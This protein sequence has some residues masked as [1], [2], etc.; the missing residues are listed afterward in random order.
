M[1]FLLWTLFY[2]KGPNQGRLET[3]HS[4]V[5]KSYLSGWFIADLLASIPFDIIMFETTGQT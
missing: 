2:Q 5:I 3:D 4:K 1:H